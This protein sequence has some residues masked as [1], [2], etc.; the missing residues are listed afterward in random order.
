MRP[1]PVGFA[2]PAAVAFLAGLVIAGVAVAAEPDEDFAHHAAHLRQI[3][4][5]PVE[6]GPVKVEP[7]PVVVPDDSGIPGVVAWD[8]R[9]WPG[10]R[11]PVPG[12]LPYDHHRGPIRYAVTPPAGGDHYP[13]WVN[14]G[15]YDKPIPSEKA[16]HAHEHGAVW[17]TYRPDLPHDQVEALEDFVRRQPMVAFTIKGVRRQTDERYILMSPFPGLPAPIVISSWAH[18]LRVESPDDPRLQRFV[19]TFRTN[20]KYSPEYGPTCEGQPEKLSGRPIFK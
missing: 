2:G 16:V 15:V 9:G 4:P 7:Q 6:D 12:A 13:I 5:S 10:D 8:T 11:K 19:D 1:G 20:P 3:L 18:Q 17:I 14:C